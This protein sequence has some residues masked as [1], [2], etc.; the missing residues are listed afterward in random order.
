MITTKT[1]TIYKMSPNNTNSVPLQ[2]DATMATSTPRK[3]QEER[4]EPAGT[5]RREETQGETATMRCQVRI[6]R[7]DYVATNE[8]GTHGNKSSQEKPK[9]SVNE[10]NSVNEE[11]SVNEDDVQVMEIHN[12]T[13]VD[14]ESVQA[15][16]HQV[17]AYMVIGTRLGQLLQSD[18]TKVRSPDDLMTAVLML[19]AL[20]HLVRL[21]DE[22]PEFDAMNLT[23]MTAEDTKS[24]CK[25][26][27]IAPFAYE[28]RDKQ[29]TSHKAYDVCYTHSETYQELTE[30][31]PGLPF[32]IEHALDQV[33]V[34]VSCASLKISEW[35]VVHTFKLRSGI[36]TNEF[37]HR[38][39]PFTRAPSTILET[40]DITIR[41][42]LEDA[43][44]QIAVLRPIAAKAEVLQATVDKRQADNALLEAKYVA[45]SEDFS[46]DHKKQFKV[47][48]QL[49]RDLEKC[50]QDLRECQRELTECQ[51]A[52]DQRPEELVAN[53][54][55]DQ[56]R[57]VIL[58]GLRTNL[59]TS[60]DESRNTSRCNGNDTETED[61]RNLSRSS[62]RSSKKR[63]SSHQ[64]RDRSGSRSSSKK[65]RR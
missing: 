44:K 25:K 1:S 40:M 7:Q 23:Q 34:Y 18:I 36:V 17:A 3:D 16:L 9:D 22:F 14:Q 49:E 13:K 31:Q 50:Q 53:L 27:P 20:K 59:D 63:D 19:D 32:H 41:R 56:M 57:M 48:R 10:E 38:H 2:K 46:A 12:G 21:Q 35:Q 33:R 51:R 37:P 5:T 64:D 39:N 30:C 15:I 58:S 8:E 28:S 52:R 11:D 29:W 55:P 24:L 61:E 43:L 4:N 47:I 26:L 6:Q 42:K 45:L 60:R 62:K 65:Y 54:S